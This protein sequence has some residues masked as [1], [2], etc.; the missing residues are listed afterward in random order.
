MANYWAQKGW[1]ITILLLDKDADNPFFPLHPDVEV[2]YLRIVCSYGNIAQLPFRLSRRIA[3]LKRVIKKSMPDAVISF[4][5]ENN[6]MTI[7]ATYGM[8]IPVIVSERSD[9]YHSPIKSSWNLLRKL[10]YSHASCV[11]AQSQRALSYFSPQVQKKGR[12]IPNPVI[13]PREDIDSAGKVNP[14]RRTLIAMGRLVEQ[15]GLPGLMQAFAH[16]A[17]S[18]TDWDLKIYGEGEQRHELEKQIADLHMEERISLPGRTKNPHAVMRAADMFVLSSRYEGFPNVLCEAMACGLPVIS[19]DCNSG[20][21]DIIRDG[22]DGVLV[23]PGDVQALAA[24][25]ARLMGDEEERNRLASRAP[26]VLERFSLE[27]VMGMWEELIDSLTDNS[28]IRD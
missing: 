16:I 1:H 6:V 3:I 9:P 12:I 5:D 19:F 21:R 22:V 26:E 4:L 27:K 17:P 28:K 13:I 7:L 25:M 11:V 20:P 15:K 24:A 14:D 18:Y 23:P 8:G 2:K 10:T